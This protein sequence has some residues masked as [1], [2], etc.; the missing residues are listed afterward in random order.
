MKTNLVKIKL[1]ALPAILLVIP[2]ILAACQP[3]SPMAS[4]TVPPVQETPTSD[5]TDEPDLPGTGGSPSFSVDELGR[6]TPDAVL[7]ELVFE[8]TFFRPE[9]SYEFGRPPVFALL[10]DGRVIYT[11]E[12]ET[13]EQEQVMM[14][15]LTPQETVALMQ[16]VL[17]LGFDRLESY[18]DFC[19][20]SPNGEQSCIAD[21]AYTILRMRRADDGLNEVKIYADF[22][23]DLQAFESIR[24]LL[25]G[26]THPQA[27]PYVPQQ[28]ALFLS[29]NLGEA[30]A[31]VL[32]WPLDPSLLEFP[33][34]DFNLWAI[35][36]EGEQLSEYISAVGRNTG[37]AFLEHEG[38]VYRAFLSPWLPAADFSDDLLA[39]FPKP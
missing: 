21:A 13:F 4:P 39:E 5:V 7:L 23:N 3:A 34:T 12:G 10:A 9:A 22:A 2:L 25:V 18:T 31:T 30:P 26:Y 36:L 37:D 14:A 38:V 27:Q 32:D 28:A 35:K 17:D 1:A 15:Q 33:Q 24:D 29:E 6:L 20:T 16:Q 8:P 11:H 19:F